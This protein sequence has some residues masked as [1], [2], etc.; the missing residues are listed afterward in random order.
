M[1]VLGAGGRLVLRRD[2]PAALAV[3]PA[4]L[5]RKANAIGIN[6]QDF[7]SGDAVTLTSDR[8]LPQ[9]NVAGVP[10][11]ADGFASYYGSE[12]FLGDN[13]DHIAS[14]DAKFYRAD[15]ADFYVKV[16]VAQSLSVWI[17]RDKLDRVSFYTTHGAALNGDPNGRLALGAVDWG[18]LIIAPAGSGDYDNAILSCAGDLGDYR[19]SDGQD[20]V[21]L[22]SICEFAPTYEKPE[23]G[24]SE[25]DDADIQP[26]GQIGQPLWRVA[27]DIREWSLELSAP[28][29]ET[30]AVGEKFGEAV[31][32]LVT[33]GGSIDFLIDRKDEDE[34]H[35]DSTMLL[36]LLTMTEQGCKA[37]AQF[38]M[39]D[40]GR[41][42]G[43]L[44]GDL[45]YETELLVTNVAI[46]LR[47]TEV[48]AGTAQFVTTGSIALKQGTN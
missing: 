9:M 40:R 31:K 34:A 27:C 38:W 48:V 25:Y 7:W 5:N 10:Q 42:C 12:W 33:G 8:G 6:N 37:A 17:Y 36:Q 35:A 4:A 14:D 28:N 20:E 13:R 15:A 43:L 1:A 46:N 3:S 21:T 47:P 39:I 23:A 16:P 45:Y 22:A 2:A 44:T 32:S 29:I 19:F 41:A 18:T 24:T 30:T 11:C 26:R